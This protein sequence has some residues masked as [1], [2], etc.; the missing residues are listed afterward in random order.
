MLQAL[1]SAG[2]GRAQLTAG[3]AQPAWA[4]S[5]RQLVRIAYTAGAGG[6]GINKLAYQH[7]DW[8]MLVLVV[9]LT[10]RCIV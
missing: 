3:L 4:I 7:I 2:S 8:N 10:V 6:L 5:R 1:G 9:V